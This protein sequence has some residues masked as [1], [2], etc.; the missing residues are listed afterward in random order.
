MG[1]CSLLAPPV[2]V[3][4]LLLCLFSHF[5]QETLRSFQLLTH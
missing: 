3:V 4:D 2:E 5:V 1:L